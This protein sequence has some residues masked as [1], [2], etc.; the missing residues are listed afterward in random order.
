MCLVLIKPSLCCYVYI[1]K[2]IVYSKNSEIMKR[3]IYVTLLSVMLSFGSLSL[4]ATTSSHPDHGQRYHSEHHH[5]KKEIKERSKAQKRYRKEREK[6]YR[7]QVKF[8]R[9]YHKE[10]ERE[11][12]NMIRHTTR[13]AQNIR[14]WQISDDAYMISYFLGGRQFVQKVYPYSGRYGRKE[15]LNI[16]LTPDPSWLLIPDIHIHLR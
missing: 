8:M 12:W 9:N 3:I 6:R 4:F 5:N 7:R 16:S 10:R 1:A 2:E 15:R 11:F 14:V 13:G